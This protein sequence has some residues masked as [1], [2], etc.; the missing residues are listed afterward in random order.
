M[1][2]RFTITWARGRAGLGE[3]TDQMVSIIMMTQTRCASACCHLEGLSERYQMVWSGSSQEGQ[4]CL[5]MEHNVS[6]ERHMFSFR[7]YRHSYV[8]IR[9]QGITPQSHWCQFH[10]HN[11]I[12]GHM[13]WTHL[14][15]WAW[16]KPL[17]PS[18][19]ALDT[20]A[21]NGV[22]EKLEEWAIGQSQ[23]ELSRC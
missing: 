19:T 12:S 13:A 7:P 4:L 21:C 11:E 23:L 17:G 3:P 20:A 9:L 22:R 16:M 15:R 18:A 2:L 5:P 6:L 1:N 14:D 10:H 8:T